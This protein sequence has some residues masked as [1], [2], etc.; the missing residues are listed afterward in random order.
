MNQSS[1]SIIIPCAGKSSRFNSLMPKPLTTINGEV[2]L[3]ILL[4]II[5]DSFDQIIIPISPGSDMF[6]MFEGLIDKRFIGKVQ[7]VASTPGR[8]DGGAILDGMEFLKAKE[9]HFFVCWGDT[10][11]INNY[12]FSDLLKFAQSDNFSSFAYIPLVYL[13]N[14]YVKYILDEK[15]CILDAQ[16]SIDGHA[17]ESGF[18]DQS[19]FMLSK[20]IE[21]FLRQASLKAPSSATQSPEISLLR[22]FRFM[23][24]K[25]L[26]LKPM[27]RE[28]KD[29]LAFNTIEDLAP[30]KKL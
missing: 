10:Y 20:N 25:N 14:P 11:I 12:I 30:I 15:N 27:I 16:Q 22:S 18:A 1:Y 28:S 6:E 19:I 29:S 9:D 4:S 5:I 24:S 26:T 8:G 3:N 7:L 13:N 23:V 21:Q 17:F 2:S